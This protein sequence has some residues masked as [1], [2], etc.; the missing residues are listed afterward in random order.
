MAANFLSQ[1]AVEL[2]SGGADALAKLENSECNL[3]ILDRNL[4]DL[5]ADELREL[6]ARDYGERSVVSAGPVFPLGCVPD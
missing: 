6:A 5:N 3:L 1:C 2:A 4:L